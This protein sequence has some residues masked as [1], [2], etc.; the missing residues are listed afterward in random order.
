MRT[1]LHKQ[2]QAQRPLSFRFARPSI[3]PFVLDHHE[4]PMRSDVEEGSA[5]TVLPRFGYDFSRIPVY[6]PT[7]PAIQTKLA[8][9]NPGDAYEHEADRISEKVMAMPEPQLK[10]AFACDGKSPHV[11]SR[12]S[13]RATLATAS[14]IDSTGARQVTG[15]LIAHEV[16]R[17]PGRYKGLLVTQGMQSQIEGLRGR[18]QQLTESLRAYFEPR[19][20]YDFGDVRVHTGSQ[21]AEAAQSINAKA[22]TVGREVAFGAGQYSPET[23]V[24]KRLLAHELTHVIQQNGGTPGRLDGA[25]RGLTI[26]RQPGTDYGLAEVGSQNKYVAEAIRLWRNQ[27]SMKVEDFADALMKAVEADLLSQGVPEFKWQM[28]SAL[29]VSGEFDSEKWVVKINPSKFSEQKVTTVQDLKLEEVKEVVGTLYHESR[30]AD[31]DALIVRV[32]LD[33]KTPVKEIA[34]ETKIPERIIKEVEANSTSNI[35]SPLDKARVAHANRMFEVMYGKHKELLTFL[36]ENSQSV[37]GVQQLVDARNADDLKDAK[38]H[39]EKLAEWAKN[40][41]EPKVKKLA[42]DK[43]LGS[44][45]AQLKQDLDALSQATTKLLAAFDT[46][47]KIKDPTEASLENLRH[48]A[49]EWQKRLFAAYKNLEGEKDALR[50]EA[51]VKEAF[52]KEAT[53]KPKPTKTEKK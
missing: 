26:Q 21:A 3:A 7:A 16:L 19:F 52:E 53:A 28:D 10:H 36:M 24:G 8:I 42:A 25:S 22:F 20:G 50:I 37:E 9:N 46:A 5:G 33:Q 6:P 49:D 40:V 4:H 14:P 32:L 1:Y 12:T 35:K 43:K 44:L 11:S 47:F 39:V 13:R 17:S 27:K 48:R 41:L 18:G 2:N 31:Q 51:L 30:H 29:G 15:P 45:E 34:K 23:S 38:P